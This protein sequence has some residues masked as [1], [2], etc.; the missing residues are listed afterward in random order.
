MLGHHQQK[1]MALALCGILTFGGVGTA[2]VV[3]EAAP[4][5]RQE[6][7]HHNDNEHRPAS[8]DRQHLGDGTEHPPASEDRHRIEKGA[9]HR[10]TPEDKQH[11]GEQE[12][13]KHLEQQPKD[14]DSKKTYSEGERNTAAI[15]GAVVGAVIAKNT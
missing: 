15:V 3:G 13:K 6:N 2:T 1:I 7:G 5:Q 12:K 8:H 11:I 9:E 10:P 4:A 14:N